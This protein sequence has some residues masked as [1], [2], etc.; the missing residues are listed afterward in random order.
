MCEVA[1]HT[2]PV[3]KVRQCEVAGYCEEG[4]AVCE[5]A[6]H[7]VLVRKQRQTLVLSLLSPFYLIWDLSPCDGAIHIWVCI[8][9]SVKSF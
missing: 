1:G 4:V 3:R 7:T 2:V 8:L 6:G 9:D 5:V